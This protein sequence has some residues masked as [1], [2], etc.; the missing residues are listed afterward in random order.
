MA[1][2]LLPLVPTLL[3][4]IT[5]CVVLLLE[6]APDRDAAGTGAV[7]GL[8]SAL[9]AA[10]LL[11]F[12][13][14]SAEA[15]IDIDLFATGFHVIFC[16]L[17]LVTAIVMPPPRRLAFPLFAVVGM[18][19]AASADDLVTAILGIQVAWLAS[20]V[21]TAVARRRPVVPAFGFT[22]VLV[23]V[24]IQMFW[25][26]G[27]ALIYAMAGTT[28]LEALAGRIAASSLDPNVLILIAVVCLLAGMSFVVAAVPFH[29]WSAEA[30]D[31]TDGTTAACVTTGLRLAGFA[32]MIRVLMTA[33]EP[34]RVE[35]LPM[36]SALAGLSLILGAVV[37][38][39]QSN[40]RRL[41]ADIGVAHAGWL[42]V[43]LAAGTDAGKTA[44]LFGLV[45][46]A[47]ANAGA[48]VALAALSGERRYEEFRDFAGL[49]DERPVV[50]A[51]LAVSL[52][53]L[54][55]LPPSMGF[56]SRWLVVSAALQEGLV[57]MAVLM[58]L[59]GVVLVF[60]CL[61]LVVQ[62]YM[63]TPHGPRRRT[64][65]SGRRL[66]AALCAAILLVVAGL[67]PG[68]VLSLA[69]RMASAVF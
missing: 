10:V 16:T 1:T 19:V 29:Q 50:S 6:R 11:W 24:V 40:V 49:G 27:T 57:P 37:A 38:V 12:R 23:G 64:T 25:W 59:A 65:V 53:S 51:V 63:T 17:G 3:V 36:L 31:N 54:A 55:G 32:V 20:I 8:S 46:W 28:R 69:S 9:A 42:M 44:V 45:G 30:G 21:A 4:A 2:P 48:L 52:L 34:L 66:A 41:L 15:A 33:L 47:V 7:I 68:A 13:A 61:R 43:G 39:T 35:W 60:G 56:V 18:M 62:M 14:P 58:A 5:A 26:Y 22:G 67:W